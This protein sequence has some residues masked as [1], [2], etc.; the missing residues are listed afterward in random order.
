MNAPSEATNNLKE[1]SLQENSRTK[2]AVKARS[3]KTTA[4][5]GEGGARVFSSPKT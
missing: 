5:K 2:V 4:K 3:K 1:K